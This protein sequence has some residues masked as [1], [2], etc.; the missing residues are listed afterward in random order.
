MPRIW[1]VATRDSVR[2]SASEA[3]ANHRIPHLTIRITLFLG[4]RCGRSTRCYRF[5]D[6]GKPAQAGLRRPGASCGVA[7]A[8]PFRR[9]EAA[10]TTRQ[11][12][13]P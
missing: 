4:F 3:A 1:A 12:N 9:S 13:E 11:L 10:V 8:K 7:F 6:K 5:W 2:K